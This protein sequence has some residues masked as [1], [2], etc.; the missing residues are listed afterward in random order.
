MVQQYLVN[1]LIVDEE[2]HDK[3]L[4]DLNLIKMGMYPG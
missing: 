3:L 2:K 4:D 1:Y